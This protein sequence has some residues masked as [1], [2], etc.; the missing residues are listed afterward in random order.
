MNLSEYLAELPR[1][2][3]KVLALRL[4]VTASYLSRLVSGDRAITAERA[5]QIESATDG[6]V[7]RHALRPDLQWDPSWNVDQF[8]NAKALPTLN[9]NVRS[10][11]PP[12]QSTVGAGVLSSSA[13]V[14]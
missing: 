3:K 8:S 6:N 5:L 2:G 13:E 11:S 1:G 4:G 14:A 10:I 12:G 7:S 9:A